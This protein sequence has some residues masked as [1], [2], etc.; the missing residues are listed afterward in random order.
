[1][2]WDALVKAAWKL[3]RSLRMGHDFSSLKCSLAFL[4]GGACVNEPVTS[5]GK[6]L[7]LLAQPHWVH[8]A[9]SDPAS[10]PGST[11]LSV[12]T[13]WEWT[14]EGASIATFV[15]TVVSCLVPAKSKR[16]IPQL[17]GFFKRVARKGGGLLLYSSYSRA[18]CSWSSSLCSSKNNAPGAK[19]QQLGC[20]T[21][22]IK[23]QTRSYT[24]V[25]NTD[26]INMECQGER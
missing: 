7:S 12:V 15:S 24:E 6:T 3:W 4:E 19:I 23:V 11:I 20:A 13:G 25:N 17:L 2:A 1:M 10:L 16:E 14:S 21:A 26:F 9:V 22:Q 8:V 18:T 5:G